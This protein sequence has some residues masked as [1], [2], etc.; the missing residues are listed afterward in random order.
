MYKLNFRSILNSHKLNLRA[1]IAYS[2][3]LKAFFLLW[4]LIISAHGLL[5]AIENNPVK[6]KDWRTIDSLNALSTS[7]WYINPESTIKL[8]QQALELSRNSG[9]KR[10]EAEALNNIGVGYYFSSDYD[11]VLDY[12][13]RTLNTYEEMGDEEGIT[14]AGTIYFRI[15]KYQKALENYKASLEITRKTGDRKQIAQLISNI[16]EVY[17]NLGDYDSA[18]QWYDNLLYN[19]EQLQDNNGAAVTIEKIGR[20]YYGR[21][22]Y[23]NALTEFGKLLRIYTELSSKAGIAAALNQI[24]SVHFMLKDYKNALESFRQ[25]LQIQVEIV[26]EFGMAANYLN[27]ARLNL[28]LKKLPE[29]LKWAQKAVLLARKNNE[30]EQLREGLKL[31]SLVYHDMGNDRNAFQSQL[32]YSAMLEKKTVKD[33]N[34]QLA[35]TLVLYELGQKK[36]ENDILQ[37]RSE[38][39]RLNLEKQLLNKWRIVLGLTILLIIIAIGIIVYRYILKRNENIRLEEEVREAIANQEQQQKIIFHQASLTSLGELAAGLAHEIN[40]PMQNISLS[41]E[42]I[43]DELSEQTP[44]TG[45]VKNT[46]KGIFDDIDRVRRIVDHIRIFSSGQ[47]EEVSELFSPDEVI[48]DALKM[49]QQQLINHGITPIDHRNSADARISGN[50]HKFEQVILNLLSNARD[51]LDGITAKEKMVVI[52]T[53]IADQT[54]IVEIT[55]NGIGIEPNKLTDIFLPFYTT[56]K[57]GQGTGLGLSIA[58]GIINQMNGHIVPESIPGEGTTMK[59]I[60]PTE[61]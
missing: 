14:R 23:E 29:S 19:Q 35:N 43:R 1:T 12:Y 60:I 40:Q 53:K 34:D 46:A 21:G 48:S 50:P 51:A 41:A 49:I 47:K 13:R 16:A 20:L 22:N 37:A 3:W 24:G 26:D 17:Y 18:L 10:G 54:L 9:Y 33:R 2:R 15:A 6:P 52:T 36:Q 11:K 58:H 61:K 38:N 27:L 30:S 56:K 25:S 7:A 5:H 28:T 42:A 45:F 32:E 59:I 57:L 31:L 39:Y 55:D 4:A 8:A 44:D